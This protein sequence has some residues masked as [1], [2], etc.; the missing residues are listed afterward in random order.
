[1]TTEMYE[2]FALEDGDTIIYHGEFYAVTS[3]EIEGDMY[4]VNLVDDEGYRRHITMGEFDKIRVVCD[5]D[6]EAVV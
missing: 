1:M 2:A 6:H 3:V 4:R 5:V